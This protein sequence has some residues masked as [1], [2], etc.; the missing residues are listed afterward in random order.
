[1]G[2]GGEGGGELSTLTGEELKATNKEDTQYEIT[3]LEE[4]LAKMKPNMAAIAEYRKKVTQ[5]VRHRGVQ[6]KG[7]PTCPPKGNP[8][9]PPKCNPTCPPNG[10]PIKDIVCTCNSNMG[11]N[12][13]QNYIGS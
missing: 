13:H 8:T 2:G 6:E 9:W 12:M 10:N 5:H 11:E 1:V 4:K 7:N 3:V